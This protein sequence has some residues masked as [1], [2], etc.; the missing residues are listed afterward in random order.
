LVSGVVLVALG[1]AFAAG[2]NLPGTSKA[3]AGEN[4]LV[5]PDARIDINSADAGTLSLLPRI[6]ETLSERIVEDRDRRGAF[7]SVE[8][9]DRVKGIGPRTVENVRAYVVVGGLD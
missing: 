3:N 7:E 6:G 8:A 5:L 2:A 1:V 9:L 4:A